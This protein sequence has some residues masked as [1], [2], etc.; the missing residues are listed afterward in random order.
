MTCLNN[1]KIVSFFICIILLAFCN[2]KKDKLFESKIIKKEYFNNSKH[3][4]YK[5]ETTEN[6]EFI[7]ETRYYK[8]GNIIYIRILKSNKAVGPIITYYENGRIKTKEFWFNGRLWDNGTGY[9]EL[10]HE[11]GKIDRKESFYKGNPYGVWSIYDNDGKLYRKL[12]YVSICDHRGN[13]NEDIFYDKNGQIIK[14]KSYY[15]SISGKDSINIGEEYKLIIKL[16]SPYIKDSISNILCVIGVM[17]KVNSCYNLI[18]SLHTSNYK[19]LID[20]L[21]H[22]VCEYK[23]KPCKKGITF[24]S[25]IIDEFV[26]NDNDKRN[27]NYYFTKELYVK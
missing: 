10:Y 14:G 15:F 11:N 8:N 3:V 12:K 23:F 16:E 19:V 18:D 25:G 20:T 2:C 22:Y 24:I 17:D 7:K 26:A 1:R 6:K 9:Y 5:L 27:R 13:C 4:L 21:N